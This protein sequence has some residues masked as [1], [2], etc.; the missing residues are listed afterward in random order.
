VYNE[1]EDQWHCADDTE[2]IE[3]VVGEFHRD[4]EG[5]SECG[6]VDVDV[7]DCWS[8]VFLFLLLERLLLAV[9]LV[10]VIDF[11]VDVDVVARFATSG[12]ML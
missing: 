8:V 9:A 1:W 3:V 12:V 2:Y 7:V 10:V 5:E 4:L 6:E 11:A